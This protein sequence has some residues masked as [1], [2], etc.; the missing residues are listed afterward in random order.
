MI[1]QLKFVWREMRPLDVPIRR[2]REIGKAVHEAVARW[3]V[4]KCLPDH[5]T[6]QAAAKYGYQPRTLTYNIIK[7][8][9]ILDGKGLPEAQRLGPIDL[10]YSG[11]MYRALMRDTVIRTFPSRAKVLMQGPQY[12]SGVAGGGI[13][14]GMRL[15]RKGGYI[16]PKTGRVKVANKR[17]DMAREIKK[18]TTAQLLESAHQ[19]DKELTAELNINNVTIVEEL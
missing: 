1:G 18:D 6:Q 8:K 7:T 11:R 3:W 17:P 9:R 16:N 2:W 5:F 12:I 13:G 19:F 4:E 14:T 10:V 15:D